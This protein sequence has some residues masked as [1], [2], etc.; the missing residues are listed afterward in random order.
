MLDCKATS[1]LLS[2]YFDGELAGHVTLQVDSHLKVCEHCRLELQSFS[3]LGEIVR[4]REVGHIVM[5][6]WDAISSRLESPSV[7]AVSTQGRQQ[8][9]F[10][11]SNWKTLL[12]LAA[13]FLMLIGGWGFFQIESGNR[14]T[15]TIASLNLKPVIE[16]FKV[17]A[18]QALAMLSDEFKTK[19][20]T[21]D[22][23]ITSFGRP[24]LVS[25]LSSKASLPGDGQLV[26]TKLLSFPYCKCPEG[27][28]MCGPGGCSCVACVCERPDGSTY[29]V[30]EHCKS[31]DI[32]FGDLPVQIVERGGRQVQRVTLDGA[33][34]DSWL[35]ENGRFTAI[36]LRN[37]KELDVLLAMK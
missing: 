26:S 10:L 9:N 5:P 7:Q 2:A 6:S 29:L 21:I 11:R 12:A 13:C 34:A 31:Q 36:G 37:E 28:C 30:L 17:D 3:S 32:S 24:L 4:G 1:E 20:S 14:Q 8:P 23:A 33:R 27:M 18:D 35:D 19:N 16:G 15:M 22:E 25:K